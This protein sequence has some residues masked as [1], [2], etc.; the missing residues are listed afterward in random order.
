MA[1]PPLGAVFWDNDGVLV[2]TEELYYHATRAVLARAGCELTIERYCDLSLRQGRSAFDLVRDTAGDDEIEVLRRQ[3][4]A[5]YAS[6]LEAGVPALHGITETLATL[7]GRVTMAVVTSCNPEHFALI[8][9]GTGLLPYFD[10]VLTNGDYAHTKPHPASYLAALARAGL[11]AEQCIAVE[12]SERGLAAARAAG[13]RCIVVPR[14]FTR[15]GDF[16]G[17]YRI[18]EDTREL[19]PILAALL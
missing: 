13:L 3:R 10:F 12:D 5:L 17:A 18:V 6:R 7:H 1:S 16:S 9:R 19:G 2:D 8:H 15:G 11:P 14:G 4:N